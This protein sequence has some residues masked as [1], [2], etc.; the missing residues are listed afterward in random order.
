MKKILVL[1]AHPDDET[2]GCGA[3]I[4][5]L[6]REGHSI[7]L[8]TF[9][10]GESSRGLNKKNRNTLLDRVSNILGISNFSF[11]NFPDNAMDSVPFLKICKF[12]EEKV[13]Y[14]PDIIFTHHHEDL[15]IDHQLVSKATYTVFR[16]Q[17]GSTH[18]IF[19]YHVPS[20]TDYNPLSSFKGNTYFKLTKQDLEKKMEA[21]KVYDK[22]I[23][24]FPHSRSYKNIENLISTYGCEVGSIYCEKFNLVRNVI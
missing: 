5:R 19:S 22:E 14:F 7:Q 24:D 8:L 3:T 9:T 11:S 15:N 13:D 23:R 6:Y 10:D 16:P 1:A 20:S 4:H 17:F 21:L 12:I 2:L 18:Q